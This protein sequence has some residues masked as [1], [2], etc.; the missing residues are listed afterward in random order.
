MMRRLLWWIDNHI[1]HRVPDWAFQEWFCDLNDKL[2]E[3]E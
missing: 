1:N 2:L 3:G